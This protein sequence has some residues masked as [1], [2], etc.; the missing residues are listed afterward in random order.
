MNKCIKGLVIGGI[1]GFALGMWDQDMKSMSK[2]YMRK[3]KK[4]LRSM[5]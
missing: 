3:G 5:L 4:I 2:K 1:V